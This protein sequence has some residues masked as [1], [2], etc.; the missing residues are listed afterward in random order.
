MDADYT[1][2]SPIFQIEESEALQGILH[3]MFANFPLRMLFS[4]NLKWL[5]QEQNSILSAAAIISGANIISLLAGVIR[6]RLLLSYFGAGSTYEAYLVAFQIPDLM[7]QLIVLGALSAAF[8]PIFSKVKKQDTAAAFEMSSVILN[9]LLIIF[10]VIGVGVFLASEYIT[11][12]RTGSQFTPEQIQIA[13]NLTKIMLVTQILFAASNVFG[14]ILQSYQRFI[15]PSLAPILY[16]VGIVAGVFIFADSYGIYSAGIGGVIGA[17]MHMIIQLPLAY[18]FG[19][20]FSF[21]LN[22]RKTGVLPL[23]KMMPPRMLS[24]GVNEL[25]NLSLGFFATTI[26]NLSFLV[27]K[28]TLTLMTIPIRLFGTPIGQASLPFLSEESEEKDMSR[29]RELVMQSLHQIAFLAFPASV[30]ILILRVPIVRLA[31]GAK[32]FPWSTTLITG[33]AV[34]IISI[35]IAAQAM[36]QLLLRAFYAL[37]DTRTPF[38]ITVITV[39]CYLVGAAF[40]SYQTDLGVYGLAIVTTVVALL[41][42]FLC[43]L[44]LHRKIDGFMSRYFWIPQSKMM[45]A[46]FF[47]AVF[48]YLPFRIFDELIFDTTRTI[49]LIALTITT[50]TIGM[51]VYLYFAALFEIKELQFLVQMVR[52][53][54]RSRSALRQNPEMVV[55]AHS[56]DVV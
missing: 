14:A 9:Y 42:L 3:A 22:L 33:R 29:F 11:T 21:S 28:L 13:A 8:I 54:Q 43:L 36:V 45:L 24:I 19:F 46:S 20:R 34:A 4:K 35:S 47:M 53:F 16:N 15:I 17:F 5:E 2:S 40:V 32:D 39:S 48:L 52:S 38:L 37:K 7:F 51:L 50:G 30:M 55:D 23:L 12:I 49:E 18:R 44:F 56:E 25:Q 10:A 6:Q 1:L 27:M 31:F 41:E 26:G